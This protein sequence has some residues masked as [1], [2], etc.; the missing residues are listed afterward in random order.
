MVCFKVILIKVFKGL[1]EIKVL[2]DESEK[3]NCISPLLLI[4]CLPIKQKLCMNEN[5]ISSQY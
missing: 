3:V 4:R 1:D 5:Q 2:F